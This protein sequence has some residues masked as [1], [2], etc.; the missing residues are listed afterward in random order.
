[1]RVLG[2]PTVDGFPQLGRVETNIVTFLAVKEGSA[3]K[4]QL[5]HAVWGG[6][7]VSDQTLFNRVAK[8]R[9]V[10]GEYLPART[11]SSVTIDLDRRVGTDLDVLVGALQNS[12]ALSAV[13]AIASLTA[14]LDLVRGVPFDGADFDW[15]HE[16]QFVADACETVEAATLRVVKLALELGDPASAR[17]AICQGLRALP[18]N[19]PIYRARMQIEHALGNIDGVNGALREL[20]SVLLG[21]A[22]DGFEFEPSAETIDLHRRLSASVLC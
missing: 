17:Q 8:T 14:A 21:A 22:D 11:R 4:D 16:Q 6:R 1:M 13:Q 20:T 5:V 18:G 10:L 19:E 7:L 15:A 12:V 2:P 3:T 9:A